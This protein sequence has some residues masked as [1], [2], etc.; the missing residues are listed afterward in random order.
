MTEESLFRVASLSILMILT[1]IGWY[2][3]KLNQLKNNE[4]DDKK[5]KKQAKKEGIKVSVIVG[6]IYMIVILGIAGLS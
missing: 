2:K 6:V 1:G 4:V 5:I 3:I